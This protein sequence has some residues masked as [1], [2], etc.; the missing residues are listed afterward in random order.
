MESQ[1][2][3]VQHL[4]VEEVGDGRQADVRVRPHVYAL[5]RFEFGGAHVVQ[6]DEGPHHPPF[7]VGQHPLHFQTAAEIP[8]AS[9]DDPFEHWRGSPLR[10]RR[11]GILDRIPAVPP[12]IIKD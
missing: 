6:E 1:A 8:A 9:F 2:V 12:R 11:D 7:R 10:Y 5:A 4:T 3:A